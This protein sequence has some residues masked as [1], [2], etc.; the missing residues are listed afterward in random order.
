MSGFEHK[1]A[2]QDISRSHPGTT[3]PAPGVAVNRPRK[4]F[5][6]DPTFPTTRRFPM[7]F[8]RLIPWGWRRERRMRH[9]F[10]GVSQ[11]VAP[12]WP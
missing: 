4:N 8:N 6:K 7:R 9:V 11:S 2:V 1:T 10:T 12:E 3:D 5:R